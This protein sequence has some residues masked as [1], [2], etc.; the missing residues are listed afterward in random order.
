MSYRYLCRLHFL[1]RFKNRPITRTAIFL[2]YPFYFKTLDLRSATS[3]DEFQNYHSVILNLL[4]EKI[5]LAPQNK[6]YPKTENFTSTNLRDTTSIRPKKIRLRIFLLMVKV[7]LLYN[8]QKQFAKQPIFL[9]I[10]L[11][12]FPVILV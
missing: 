4:H 2:K 11:V 12:Q 6:F 7:I 8:H 5:V 1:A 9:A 3:G 10:K